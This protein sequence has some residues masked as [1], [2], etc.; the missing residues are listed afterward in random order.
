LIELGP[1]SNDEMILS[2]IRA[3]IDS[4]RWGP[5]YAAALSERGFDRSSLIDRPDLKDSDANRNREILLGDVRGYGRNQLL[6]AKFPMDTKWRRAS[7][8][9]TEF[10]GL[11]YIGNDSFWRDLTAGSRSVEDGA[12]NYKGSPIADDV[13][14]VV[15]EISRETSIP[16]LILVESAQDRL[17]VLD[18]SIRATAYVVAKTRPILALVGSSPTMSRWVFA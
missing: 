16:E 8:G 2:F 12:K 10:E 4:R 14:S 13:D 11:R 3:E 6:F 9:P 5:R 17:V 1:A 15:H 7:L 18:G